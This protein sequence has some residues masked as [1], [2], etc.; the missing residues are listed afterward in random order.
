MDIISQ[1]ANLK[2]NL[3]TRNKWHT[4]STFQPKL[5]EK[6]LRNKKST[7]QSY[8]KFDGLFPLTN[9]KCEI[10]FAKELSLTFPSIKFRLVLNV[11]DLLRNPYL[12]P[13]FELLCI[14]DDSV[15]KRVFK[16]PLFNYLTF[17]RS[18]L[19][20]KKEVTF[21]QR[22]LWDV[23]RPWVANR[24]WRLRQDVRCC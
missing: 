21:T 8:K 17:L 16:H 1:E 11:K 18:S 22:Y 24:P 15:P 7:S 23:W 6:E 14:W 10:L 2:F 5:Q 9:P 20:S 12:F 19:A 4:F 3:K 13:A